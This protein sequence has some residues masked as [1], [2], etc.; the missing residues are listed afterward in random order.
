MNL[1]LGLART[2]LP[3]IRARLCPEPSLQGLHFLPRKAMSG[4]IA[5][6]LGAGHSR[7]T[8]LSATREGSMR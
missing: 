4:I 7:E 2:I 3:P 6:Q 8:T 1:L 5:T